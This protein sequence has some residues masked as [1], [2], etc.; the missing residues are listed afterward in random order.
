YGLDLP[1]EVRPDPG[2]VVELL[3]RHPGQGLGEVADGAGGVPVGADPERVGV[4]E[5]QQVRHLLE[6]PSYLGFSM[7]RPRPGDLLSPPLSP[8]PGA[9]SPG[10]GCP[11][12]WSTGRG[13]RSRRGSGGW[14]AAG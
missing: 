4:L 12:A 7:T 5:F 2:Q 8:S 6:E 1:G 10:S 3:R 14:A 13:P 9:A 11:S